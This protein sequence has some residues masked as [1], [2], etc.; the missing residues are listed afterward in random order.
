MGN[1]TTVHLRDFVTII[2]GVKISV[3]IPA[4]NEEEFLP[5]CLSSLSKQ[6]FPKEDYEI[7]VVDN[8]STD[9]TPILAKKYRARVVFE[10]KRGIAYAR[11]KG[12]EE[13]Q[14]EIIVGIDAD[15][16]VPADFLKKIDR[17]F[18][19]KHIV[20]LCGTVYL[21]DAPIVIKTGARILSLYAH[22]KS[23]LF[24]KTP[25]CWALNFSF[26]RKD[27]EKVGGYNLDLPMLKAGYNTQ[28]SDEYDM[29]EKLARNGGKILFD[30]NIFLTTSGRR[31]KNR[32]MYWF[33]VEY[34]LGFVINEKFYNRFGFFIPFSSYYERIQPERSFNYAISGILFCIAILSALFV[35]T[36]K[37][38]QY[39]YISKA[40]QKEFKKVLVFEANIK[41]QITPYLRN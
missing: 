25:I 21:E 19:D 26:R 38:P 41:A 18:L 14:G 7:L 33:F 9:Q 13:A 28:G 27:F 30:H 31:F 23:R 3:V 2:K 36:P 5:L 29:V 17:K 12:A 35:F 6:S 4:Y 40:A 24:N 8:N 22:A 32:L 1:Y 16:T 34:L 20:G 11:Q 37:S 10:P 39:K 15:C